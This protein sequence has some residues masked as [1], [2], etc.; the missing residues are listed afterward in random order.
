[1]KSLSSDLVGTG[2]HPILWPFFPHCDTLDCVPDGPS[3]WKGRWKGTHGFE[4]L[5]NS[6]HFIYLTLFL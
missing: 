6:R 1:M 4:Q 3:S 5:L 2:F